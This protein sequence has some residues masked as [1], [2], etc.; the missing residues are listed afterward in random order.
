MFTFSSIQRYQTTLMLQMQGIAAAA[1]RAMGGGASQLVVAEGHP[2]AYI[3]QAELGA[4]VGDGWRLR[5]NL[6]LN[7]GLRYESQTNIHDFSNFSP[8]L[9]FAWAP[10]S[11]GTGSARTVVRG[12]FAIFYQRFE[13]QNGLLAERFNRLNQFQYTISNPDTFPLIPTVLP[14]A[15]LTRRVVASD[16]RA[17]YI[18][19]AALGLNGSC[20]A[21]PRWP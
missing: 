9:G 5:P 10:G 4:F 21:K 14:A 20:L 2:F 1:I 11:K 15:T 13:E 12:G 8:R 19:Q 17:P 18:A 7:Y 16:L 3:G 6:S